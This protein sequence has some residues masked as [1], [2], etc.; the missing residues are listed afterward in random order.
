MTFEQRLVLTV[1]VDMTEVVSRVCKQFSVSSADLLG[2]R[3]HAHIAQA[4][5]VLAWLLRERGLSYPAIGKAMN[6]DHTTIMSAVR[7]VDAERAK[8]EAVARVLDEMNGLTGSEVFAD[9]FE[10]LTEAIETL[11]GHIESVEFAIEHYSHTKPV[12]QL[13]APPEQT[14]EATAAE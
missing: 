7:K 8:S 9:P 2:A 13:P 1:S 3:R 5:H 14:T 12:P 4:R 11:R 10:C 6:K